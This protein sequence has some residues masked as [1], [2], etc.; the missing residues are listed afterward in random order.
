MRMGARFERA[1]QCVRRTHAQVCVYGFC[2]RARS[3]RVRTVRR[4]DRIMLAWI[5]LL[6]LVGHDLPRCIEAQSCNAPRG[7]AICIFQTVALCMA[8][9]FLEDIAAALGQ[10]YSQHC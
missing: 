10:N 4:L 3:V 2:V 7:G 5:W 6:D 1:A 8:R 9:P